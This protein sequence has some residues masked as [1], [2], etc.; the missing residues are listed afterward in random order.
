M[1]QVEALAK[2]ARA[3]RSDQAVLSIDGN[4]PSTNSTNSNEFDESHDSESSLLRSLF[5]HIQMATGLH[6]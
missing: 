2:Y 6:W 1:T 3:S 5:K 4:R